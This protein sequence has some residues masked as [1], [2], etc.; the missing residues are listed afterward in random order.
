MYKFLLVN[1]CNGRLHMNSLS[2]GLKYLN[3]EAGNINN[4]FKKAEKK[5]QTC[6]L[7]IL[8]KKLYDRNYYTLHFLLYYIPEIFFSIQKLL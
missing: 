7:S 5:V 4:N 8:S 1:V 6:Q 3:I 2:G